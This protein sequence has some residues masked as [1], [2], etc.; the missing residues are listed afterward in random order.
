MNLSDIHFHDTKIRRVTEDT[1]TDTLTMDVRYPL[2]WENN[3]FEPR[4]LVFE[5]V[6]NYQV[7]EGPFQGCP[8]ILDAKIVG[9]DG[10][11]KRLRLETNAGYREV[12]CVAV[13]VKKPVGE[14]L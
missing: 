6:Y 13:F 12:N 8:T 2:D 4:L 10:R 14:S 7:F 1:Q 5:D 11:W 9:T 3:I